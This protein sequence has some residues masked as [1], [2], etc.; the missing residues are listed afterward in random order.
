MN[1]LLKTFQI[2]L[3]ILIASTVAILVVF[4]KSPSQIDDN[5]LE[6][7]IAVVLSII[8]G[9]YP[10]ML[11]VP[12]CVALSIIEICLCVKKNK[13]PSLIACLVFLCLLLP[14]LVFYMF[15]AVEVLAELIY[16]IILAVL[17]ICLC[18]ASLVLDCV[19]MHNAE[20]L[21]ATKEKSKIVTEEK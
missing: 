5:S 18:V 16:P 15:L 3:P 2:I 14:L 19:L 6:K 4:L 8:V 10:I 1:K 20:R 13:K 17:G 21:T 7:G 12:I 11:L 9:I